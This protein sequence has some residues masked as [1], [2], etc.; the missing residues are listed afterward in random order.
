VRVP[1]GDAATVSVYVS[2]S[3]GDAF[4][5]FTQEIDKWWRHGVKFRMA[6]RRR[7]ELF[8]ECHLGGRLFE[9]FERAGGAHTREVGKVVR[10]EPPRRFGLEWRGANFEPGEKTLVDVTFEASGE[11]TLVTVRHSGWSSL[12]DDHPARHGLAGPAFSRMIGLWWGDL[13]AA[14]RE[15]V[16]SPRT[17]S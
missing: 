11:G 3:Q 6:G 8:F 13:M 4:E 7:G 15:Y 16:I 12:R 14:L 2:V 9:T 17:R 10:W 5:V 1:P